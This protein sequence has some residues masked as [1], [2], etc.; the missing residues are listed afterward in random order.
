MQSFD[1]NLKS[2]DEFDCLVI[3]GG[4]IRGIAICGTLDLCEEHDCLINIKTYIGTSIGAMIACMLAIGFKSKELYDLMYELNWKDY[5]DIK[6]KN[7]SKFFGL[8]DGRKIMKKLK[9]LF[10]EK[11]INPKITFSQLYELNQNT[12]VIVGVNVCDHSAVYFNKDTTPDVEILDAVRISI[13]IPFLFTSPI[14]KGDY[15]ADGGLLDNCATSQV[16]KKCKALVIKLNHSYEL[17]NKKVKINEGQFEKF[18]QHLLFTLIDENNRLRKEISE[19]TKQHTE[20]LYTIEI[21]TKSISSID[22]ELT[23]KQKEYLYECGRH[24]AAVWLEEKIEVIRELRK[25]EEK[26][27]KSECKND[28]EK[29]IK[30]G[31]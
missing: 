17:K 3:S 2:L 20:N 5:R 10:K 4:G 23:D 22:M 16:P 29:Q 18:T 28:Q 14:Y 11:E 27:K 21:V 30:N 12:L 24:Y 1:I 9:D 13:S 8:D 19:L 6:L 26:K 31:N 7:F 15:F 25:L